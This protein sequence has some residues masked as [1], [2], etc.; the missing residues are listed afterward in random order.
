MGAETAAPLEEVVRTLRPQVGFALVVVCPGDP[1]VAAILRA[2]SAL[3]VVE[4]RERVQLE[5]DRVFVVPADCEATLQRGE[6]LVMNTNQPRAPIDRLLRSLADDLGGQVAGVILSGRGTDG[7]IGI[8]RVKEAGGL[9][10]AQA[11]DG[12]DSEMPRA[13]IATG[14]IDL[15]LPASEIGGRLVAFG[16][17]GTDGLGFDDERRT[18]EEAV[19]VLR[20]ILAL[21]RIRSGHDFGS[22]KRATLYRRVSR[23][24][25]VCQCD[26]IAS[27]HHYLRDNPSELANLLRDFLISVTNF[28]RD[29]TA[30]E[31]L[32]TTIIPKLFA[33]KTSNDQ[34]RVWVS[35]CATGEE[36]YS[37]GMLLCEFAARTSDCP[38]LQIFA[39]DID[40]DSLAEA[41]V[42]RYP[43]TISVDVSPERLQRFFTLDNDYYRV[44]KE[45]REV[46][47]FSPHNLLRD[48][49]FSRLDLISCRN[50]LIYL[51]RDAQDRALNVFQFG[52]RPDGFLF[53]GSSESAENTSLFTCLD[54]KHR[55]FVRRPS[56]ARLSSDT[57]VPTARWHPPAPTPAQ[58]PL[59]R[60]TAGELH[61]RIVEQYAP[62]SILVNDELDIVHISEHAGRL[63]RITGGEPTRQLLR[64]IHP[65]LRADL[66]TA[67][68]AARQ[69]ER[70]SESRTARF[71]D[72][73][74]SSRSVEIR[75]RAVARPELGLGSLLVILDELDSTRTPVA[76]DQPPNA[77]LEPVM[78]EL[79]DELRR[80][81]E[82]LRTT[83]EQYETSLEEL[84]ASNEELQSINEEL[85]SATE[86]LETSKEELQSVN[87]EL[88]TLNHELKL[89]VDE[90]SHA[91]SDLQ[92][93]MTSTDIG[94]MFLD[95]GLN[96]KR[97]TP[98]AQDLFN[99]IPSDIGR[100]IAH[101]THRLVADDL[102][103]LAQSVVQ[104][105]R[106]IEREIKSR[107][108]R[109]YLA[110]LL[111]YRSLEDRIDGVV[112][113]FVEVTDLRDAVDARRRIEAALQ[114]S[115]Q[116]LRF[117]LRTAPMLVVS[118][119]TQLQMTWGFVLGEELSAKSSRFTDLLA[120]D[121]AGRFKEITRRVLRTG[122]GQRAEID[123]MIDGEPRTYDVRIERSELGVEAVGFDITQS[124]RN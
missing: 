56:A 18:S 40:E 121:H 109:L 28:F 41:R 9:T 67:I 113:T 39:T 99:V 124:S 90:V 71:D 54:T 29:R 105:L 107:D 74:G 65:G 66:R 110:R 43:G 61:H 69:S 1:Q 108:D 16:R 26:S 15:V 48:P 117:A 120:P 32:A 38:Q 89:K 50:V 104:T 49:P 102:P 76:S 2:Q 93:L 55:L 88:T 72:D 34:V 116:R 86:E 25:Q 62:P 57:I 91:N 7:V 3:P 8:K 79:E 92:N 112:L 64:L 12:V 84:K 73:D 35:G 20:D 114:A 75:V 5:A 87:E 118:Y 47:L 123:L 81:R 30:F 46:V 4:V 60:A 58:P 23:R 42:G 51:N 45:L 27:Y 36:A 22:Y 122:E 94:V 24:M 63:L 83:I 70:G 14:L 106:T 101:L 59:E 96:I 78:R 82:Q 95:R 10:I 31:A 115:E 37:L 98:R 80:T 85:R 21:V 44:S 68:Y 19:D 52:L 53:L 11:P 33:G 6:L 13:A 17:Q 97:F 100:P 119:D 111:P 103:Q 77:A